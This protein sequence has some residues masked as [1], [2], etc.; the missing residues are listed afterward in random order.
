MLIHLTASAEDFTGSFACNMA[1]VGDATV[2]ALSC[3]GDHTSIRFLHAAMRDKGQRVSF[4]F[5]GWEEA[6]PW[7]AYVTT[8]SYEVR[9]AK[10]GYDQWHLLALDDGNQF[11]L[12]DDEETLWAMLRGER[13]TT[14]VIRQ[15][16]PQMAHSLRE[17]GL[18]EK[19]TSFGCD[20]A[21]LYANTESLDRVVSEGLMTQSLFITQPLLLEAV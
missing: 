12:H 21:M 14:P 4:K 18:L 10:L 8:T 20:A 2:H 15:W 19:L 7:K 3:T 6:G 5:Q 1:A 13:F 17:L 11:M 9:I 16:V